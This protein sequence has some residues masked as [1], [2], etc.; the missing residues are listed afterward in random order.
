MKF[1]DYPDSCDPIYQAERREDDW[2]RTLQSCPDDRY[3]V[4][5]ARGVPVT[6]DRE[7]IDEITAEEEIYEEVL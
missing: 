2:E 3:F 4:L 6:L 7:C 5:L 1:L